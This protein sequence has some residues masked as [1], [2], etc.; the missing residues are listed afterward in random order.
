MTPFRRGPLALGRGVARLG[1]GGDYNPEQWPEE[2]WAED[3]VLMSEAGVTFVTLAVFAWARLQPSPE[4]WD[5]GWLDRSLALMAEHEI[6]V[7]LA[8]ATASPPAWLSLAHPEMLPVDRDGCRLSYGS[9]QSWCASSPAYRSASL[10]L[11]EAMATRYGGHPAL[12]LWHVSNELGCHNAHCYCD[13]SST[14]FRD[15]LAKRYGDLDALNESWGTAFWSQAY[16]AWEQVSTPRAST[17]QNNPTQVLDFHRFSSDALLEQ[18][19]AERDVLRRITP[20]VPVTTNFMVSSH[21][22][23]LDYWRWAPE[24]DVISLDHYLDGRVDDP[25]VELSFSADWIRGLAGGD[26]WV[27]MEHS[28]S[29]VNWQPRNYAKDPGQ[30][31]RNSL[32]HVGRG[33]DAVGFFQWRASRAGAEKYH[34]GMLPHAGT[35]SR[36]WREVVDLGALL[37]R[38]GEVSGSR[39]VA[40]VAMV[41]DYP[42]LWAVQRDSLP[43]SGLSYRDRGLALYRALWDRGITV[44]M[45][46]ADADLTGRLLVLAPMLHLVRDDDAVSIASYVEGGGHLLTTYFSG[47]VDQNDHVRLGGYP[48][49]FRD[50]LGVRVEE[51]CPLPPDTRLSL[52]DSVGDVVGTADTW[53][54]D[55]DLRGA[56]A[57]WVYGD[58]PLPGTPAFTR[59]EQGTGVGWYL[60]TRTDPATTAAAVEQVLGELGIHGAGLPAGVELVRRR[61]DDA[62]YAFVLNHTDRSATLDLIGHDLVSDRTVSA[63]F[64]LDPGDVACIRERPGD[65]RA[66]KEGGPGAGSASS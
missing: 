50:L 8:T 9:R 30:L 35:D 42:S 53:T 24:Q 59:H 44:D 56:S 4:R 31:R 5:F 6:A 46:S 55:L 26:P 58:G 18:F 13:V 51:F 57:V 29:A 40:D 28:T 7:D 52:V 38:L 1:Y 17:A 23:A 54:E 43:V 20:D 32:Q 64:S 16:G 48:G 11:V 36:L 45:V 12:R 33:A 60:A 39:V 63:G 25:H 37:G 15:W 65:D 14:A 22:D 66:A 27:L 34:S 21:I 47:I 61:G 19:V 49:A 3:V 10:E 2:T 41:V 62:T